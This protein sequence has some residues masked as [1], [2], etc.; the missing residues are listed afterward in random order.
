MKKFVNN[1]PYHCR[2]Y[3]L[4]QG[5]HGYSVDD[6]TASGAGASSDGYHPVDIFMEETWEFFGRPPWVL[7]NPIIWA[8]GLISFDEWGQDTNTCVKLRLKVL[9]SIHVFLKE[10][11]ARSKRNDELKCVNVIQQIYIALHLSIK[12]NF[13]NTFFNLA[14]R[15]SQCHFVIV[16]T[17]QTHFF[18]ILS[19]FLCKKRSL[20]DFFYQLNGNRYIGQYVPLFF[21]KSPHCTEWIVNKLTKYSWLRIFDH[22]IKWPRDFLL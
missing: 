20:W 9:P 18:P 12:K 19:T 7:H 5:R 15:H 16:M 11:N 13:G 14:V 2:P 8:N 4:I 22:R 1:S 21:C 3:N 17:L 10:W 6:A